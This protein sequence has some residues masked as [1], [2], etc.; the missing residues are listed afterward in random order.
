MKRLITAIMLASA[1]FALQS[2]DKDNDIPDNI[3]RQAQEAFAAKYPSASHIS[4]QIKRGYAVADFRQGS[5]GEECS[6]WFDNAGKWYMTETEI[7]FDDLPEAVKTAFRGSEYA[8][9]RIDDVDKLERTGVETVYV[10]DVEK[11]ENGIETEIDLYYSSDG[12][13]VK[14]VVDTEGDNDYGDRIPPMIEAGI[15]AF[16]D[17]HYPNARILEIERESDNTTEVDILDGRTKRELLFDASLNWIRTETEI[18]TGDL[19]KAVTD[20]I[21]AQPQYAGYRIDDA[22]YIE[23][24]GGAYYLVEL[25]S[26]DSE[27]KLRIDAEGNIL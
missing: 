12:I 8:T 18:R 22:D 20:A 9:W 19:P 23:T 27:I 5:N 14:T 26:G 10:I 16:I 6:A 7:R 1:I 11:R 17:S 25:E 24:P 2:C 4:W 15:K 3:S 13:L 21:A